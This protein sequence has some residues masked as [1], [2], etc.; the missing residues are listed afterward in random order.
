MPA[1]HHDPA[2]WGHC[3]PA[4]CEYP[5]AALVIP[6]VKDHLQE[7]EVGRGD[8]V[9]EVATHHL[10]ALRKALLRC[11]GRGS[12]HDVRSVENNHWLTD[13]RSADVKAFDVVFKRR[14]CITAESFG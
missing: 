4:I 9:E 14:D 3:F 2:A 13:D 11:L 5:D 12:I 7:V 8:E 10:N 1:D 6:V